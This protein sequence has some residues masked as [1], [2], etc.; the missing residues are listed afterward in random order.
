MGDDFAYLKAEETFKFAEVF[1]FLIEQASEG[2]FEVIYSTP[3]M[4]M[5]AVKQEAFDM[6][7]KFPVYRSDF[8]PLLMQFP[9]HYWSGYYTSRPNFKK[10]VRDMGYQAFASLTQYSLRMI[11]DEKLRNE[12]YA[13]MKLL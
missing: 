1:K 5:Q 10:L 7:L 8:L 4:Y 13:I 3:S 12:Y 6:K 9:R 2:E 11:S